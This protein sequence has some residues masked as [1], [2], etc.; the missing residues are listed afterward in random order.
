MKEIVKKNR[1]VSR[2]HTEASKNSGVQSKLE[3]ANEL[4][5]RVNPLDIESIVRKP[6]HR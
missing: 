5:S 2:T 6:A 4:L 3:K 1:T